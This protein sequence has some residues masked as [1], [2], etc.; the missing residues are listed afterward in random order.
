MATNYTALQVLAPRSDNITDYVIY[1]DVVNFFYYVILIPVGFFGNL[2]TVIVVS[3]I[4]RHRQTRRSIPDVCLGLLAFVDLFSVVFIHSISAAAESKNQTSLPIGVCEYQAFVVSLYLKLQFL[5]QILVCLDRHFALVKPLQYH[6][7]SSFK[8]MKFL[9]LSIVLLSIGSTALTY[10]TSFRDVEL[11]RTWTICRFSWDFNGLAEYLVVGATMILICV[12]LIAFIVCNVAL[13]TVL[14]HYHRQKTE[15]VWKE[16]SKAV[17]DLKEGKKKMNYW[18]G[19]DNNKNIPATCET[20]HPNAAVF[21]SQSSCNSVSQNSGR[22]DGGEGVGGEEVNMN[23]KVLHRDFS[24]Q[25]DSQTRT[26]SPCCVHQNHDDVMVIKVNGVLSTTHSESKS[27]S[28]S[29]PEMANTVKQGH[30]DRLTSSSIKPEI[31][32]VVENESRGFITL[33]N[34]NNNGISPASSCT[35]QHFDDDDSVFESN[36][37]FHHHSSKSSHFPKVNITSDYSTQQFGTN[38]TCIGESLPNSN[39]DDDIKALSSIGGEGIET[40]AV[41]NSDYLHANSSDGKSSVL[42]SIDLKESI[43]GCAQVAVDYK[44]TLQQQ[45]AANCCLITAGEIDDVDLPGEDGKETAK[46]QCSMPGSL[47]AN[48]GNQYRD[49]KQDIYLGAGEGA[50]V[51]RDASEGPVASRTDRSMEPEMCDR[52]SQLGADITV[53]KSTSQGNGSNYGVR[54]CR[55]KMCGSE[56]KQRFGD[57]YDDNLEIAI[58]CKQSQTRSAITSH[59]ETGMNNA[60]LGP[61]EERLSSLSIHKTPTSHLRVSI[62]AVSIQHSSTSSSQSPGLLL[63]GSRMCSTTPEIVIDPPSGGSIDTRDVELNTTTFHQ[64]TLTSFHSDNLY[65]RQKSNESSSLDHFQSQVKK[66]LRK[67]HKTAYKQQGEIFLARMVLICAA[68]FLLSWLPYAVCIYS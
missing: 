9:L 7:F 33:H 44:S 63:N 38:N 48:D 21:K 51:K 59:K 54:N 45:R 31:D 46:R 30:L 64:P 22:G 20:K 68:A 49:L 66:I 12:G 19:V 57:K 11:L 5:L 14:W 43:D 25:C 39:N 42:N 50:V 28:N 24:S 6:K 13:V 4:V 34:N 27:N 8:T 40:P 61:Y 3:Y 47:T 1:R 16:I 15:L 36:D 29:N 65:L 35:N 41:D 18:A 2:F 26:H 10:A 53:E 55:I 56:T 52:N 32:G 62:P 17:S 67:I 37:D 60:C 58:P 23:N